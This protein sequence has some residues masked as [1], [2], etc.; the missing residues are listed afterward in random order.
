MKSIGIIGAG[1]IGSAFARALAR[2]GIEATL[3]NSRGPE[4]LAE[5]V[6]GIGPSIT[7]S[8][9]EEAAAKEMVLAQRIGRSCRRRSTAC[10]TSQG[11]S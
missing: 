10:R 5:L 1:Q 11:A 7:A 9:R 4:S 6:R 8:T 3:A 2:K